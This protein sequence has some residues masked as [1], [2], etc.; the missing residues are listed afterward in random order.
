MFKV[1]PGMKCLSCVTFLHLFESENVSISCGTLPCL[2]KL[3]SFKFPHQSLPEPSMRLEQGQGCDCHE[4][5]ECHVSC[6]VTASSMWKHD[7]AQ[8]CHVRRNSKYIGWFRKV[9]AH[10]CPP[11]IRGHICRKKWNR[12][13]SSA[14]PIN[15]LVVKVVM[16]F[17]F[18]F[19]RKKVSRLLRIGK[20][21]TNF[22]WLCFIGYKY[23]T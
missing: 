4:C 22:Y 18:N 19:Q 20:V 14:G 16:I 10:F 21:N 7:M 1:S 23:L 12:V 3:Q 6:H 17:E 9:T 8:W 15:F 5:H 13:R 11:K 2:N